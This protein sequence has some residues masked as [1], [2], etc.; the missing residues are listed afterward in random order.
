MAENVEKSNKINTDIADDMEIKNKIITLD[1]ERKRLFDILIHKRF[2]AFLDITDNQLK[3]MNIT[4]IKISSVE[5]NTWEIQYLHETKYYTENNYIYNTDSETEETPYVKKTKITFGKTDR[6]Y[7]KGTKCKF[8]IYRNSQ[9]K[10][11]VI[12]A[13]YDLE[14]DMEEQEELLKKYMENI[15][16]PESTALLF[17][18]AIAEHE[19]SDLDIVC[20]FSKL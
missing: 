1:V 14:L 7:L 9:N 8:R 12:N 11:R 10:L 4:D 6:Y 18:N 17:F 13:D 3:N 2:N 16:I 5:Q 15:H 20:Y 19:W